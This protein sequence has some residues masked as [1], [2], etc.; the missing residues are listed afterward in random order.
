MQ[1]IYG[2]P[3][4]KPDLMYE[5]SDIVQATADF[6]INENWRS[7]KMIVDKAEK[8]IPEVTFNDCGWRAARFSI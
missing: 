5:F 8:L 2:F 3:G 7:S 4:A 6:T 1:S